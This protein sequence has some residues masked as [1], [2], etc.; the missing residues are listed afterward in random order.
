[1]PAIP[2]R[3]DYDSYYDVDAADMWGS[4]QVSDAEFAVRFDRALEGLQEL[5]ADRLIIDDERQS[6]NGSQHALASPQTL[7][8]SPEE[9][10]DN[11]MQ[12]LHTFKEV[13]ADKN[14][15]TSL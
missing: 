4:E 6:A 3:M 14:E 8:G 2:D 10:I 11:R 9:M 7:Q 12:P 1:M 15:M 5:L 13:V